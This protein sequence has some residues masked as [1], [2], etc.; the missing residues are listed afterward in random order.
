VRNIE[1][2]LQKS[3]DANLKTSGRTRSMVRWV[4][5]T[6]A[7]VIT[8]SASRKSYIESMLRERDVDIADRTRVL[9]VKDAGMVAVMTGL[10]T[11]TLIDPMYDG[12]AHVL[13]EI[14]KMARA[15][16]VVADFKAGGSYADRSD[17]G[18]HRGRGRRRLPEAAV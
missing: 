16:N 12:P 17:P 1:R 18:A 5:K 11:A 4:P 6:G 9:I 13:A 15:A 14:E 8:S 2:E 3:Y 10:R 7:V